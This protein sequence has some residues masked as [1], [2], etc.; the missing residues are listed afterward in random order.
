MSTDPR[1]P[2]PSH[3]EGKALPGLVL[4]Q[5][6]IAVLAVL[7]MVYVGTQIEPLLKQKAKLET[8]IGAYQTQVASLQ[9]ELESARHDLQ[10]AKTELTTT[11][12]ALEDTQ[13]RLRETLDIAKY[14]H[15]INLIDLKVI[16]SR[17]PRAARELQLILDLQR[18]GVGWHLGGQDPR[19][20]FDS[21]SF[22]AFIL[23]TLHALP[24][25]VPSGKTLLE[26]SRRLYETLPPATHPEVGDLVFYPAGYVLFYFKDQKNQPFVIGMTPA[27]IAALDPHF[28]RPVGYRKSG[29]AQ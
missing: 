23:N 16:A 17:Y 2:A 24:A 21:P 3:Q 13:K 8:D 18:E 14:M 9:S 10:S 19:V 12:K 26:T 11:K 25:P 27:G 4:L 29:L 22:A 7:V 28:A 1:R 6:V 15:P 5:L 20:G